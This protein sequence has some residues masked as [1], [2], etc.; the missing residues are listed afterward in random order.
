M[1]PLCPHSADYEDLTSEASVRETIFTDLLADSVA[2]DDEE[3]NAALLLLD[4]LAGL[5]ARP[6]K[7]AHEAEGNPLCSEGAS[8]SVQ[9]L[10]GELEAHHEH[11]AE[12]AA[13]LRAPSTLH[14]DALAVANAK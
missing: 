12:G 6:G 14:A 5:G 3:A 10:H 13:V 7:A 8:G 11:V 2:V 9:V 1:S 4:D